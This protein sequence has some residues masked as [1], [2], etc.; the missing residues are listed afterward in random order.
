[1]TQPDQHETPRD[2]LVWAWVRYATRCPCGARLGELHECDIRTVT[3]DGER[4]MPA[5]ETSHA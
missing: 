5:E 4:M 2:R 1:M 3:M